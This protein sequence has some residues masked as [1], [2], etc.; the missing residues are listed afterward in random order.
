[1]KAF[2]RISTEYTNLINFINNSIPKYVAILKI[3][4]V[5]SWQ[6]Y[7]KYLTVFYYL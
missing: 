4:I 3:S 7:E 2:G 6:R 5:I 1:M